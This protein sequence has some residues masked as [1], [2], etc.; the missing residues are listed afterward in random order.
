MTDLEVLDTK[1]V[2]LDLGCGNNKQP[3]F[4]GVDITKD[5]TQADVEH[6][7]MRHFPWPFED[8]SVDEIF[9][10]HWFEHIPQMNRPK[11]M[12][13]MYRILKVGGTVKSV[14]PYAWSHRAIQDFTHQ[15]PPICAE[16]YLYFN[17][18]W[19]ARN[20]LEHW[21]YD[22]KCDFEVL[23]CNYY[24]NESMIEREEFKKD[25]QK[26]LASRININFVDDMVM[27]LKKR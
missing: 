14:T 21:V 10:S 22:M 15:W 11:V 19:R 4:V 5:G 24:L 27:V 2:K 9:S 18:D 13:E 23:S 3:G 6:D 8:S 17:K 25:E 12:D 20:K 16:T 26:E 7:L 1:K